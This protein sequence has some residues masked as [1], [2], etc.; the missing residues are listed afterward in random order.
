MCR[1]RRGSRTST[2]SS[3]NAGGA[4]FSKMTW[5]PAMSKSKMGRTFSRFLQNCVATMVLSYH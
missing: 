1:T 3:S 5:A 4:G 2:S